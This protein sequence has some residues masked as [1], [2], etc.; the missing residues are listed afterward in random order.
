M[1]ENR[2]LFPPEEE[3]LFELIINYKYISIIN[4]NTL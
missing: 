1:V 2:I 3:Q 4:Y